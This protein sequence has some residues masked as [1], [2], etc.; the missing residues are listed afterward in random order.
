MCSE[1]QVLSDDT[2]DDEVS[3]ALEASRVYSSRSIYLGMSQSETDTHFKGSWCTRVPSK[4][5]I[6]L[7]QVIKVDY[8][9]VSRW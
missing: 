5:K 6:F 9:R 3:W 7:W 2:L 1:I 4:I 8:H